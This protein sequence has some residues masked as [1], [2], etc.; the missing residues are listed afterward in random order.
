[1]KRYDVREEKQFLCHI[2]E[3]GEILRSGC[4]TFCP[5]RQYVEFV[6]NIIGKGSKYENLTPGET[7]ELPFCA[8]F[9]KDTRVVINGRIYLSKSLKP[10]PNA[11]NSLLKIARINELSPT[12]I[13]RTKPRS[14]TLLDRNDRPLAMIDG[15]LPFFYSRDENGWIRMKKLII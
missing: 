12:S 2:D 11:N 13:I 14:L 5:R 4:G 7:D 9:S 15:G 8:G 3:K 10:C 1:M 6:T